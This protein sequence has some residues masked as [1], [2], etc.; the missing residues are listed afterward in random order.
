VIGIQ[1]SECLRSGNLSETPLVRSHRV[2]IRTK[3]NDHARDEEFR[4][5]RPS[6]MEQFASRSANH[7]SHPSDVRSTS[8]GSPVWLID[9]A[10]EA[11][12][13]RFPDSHFPGQT[14]Q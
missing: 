6:H 1:R 10:S 8:E 4:G 2:T 5:R 12:Y 11:V 3:D 9:S 7:N 13:G 14:L